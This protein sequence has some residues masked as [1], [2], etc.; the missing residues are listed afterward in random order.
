[1]R[2]DG[3]PFGSQEGAEIEATR[4]MR[5]PRRWLPPTHDTHLVIRR[6]ADAERGRVA[7]ARR[8]GGVER[9]RDAHVARGAGEPNDRQHHVRRALDATTTARAGVVD[10]DYFF[11]VVKRGSPS[12]RHATRLDRASTHDVTLDA[13]EKPSAPRK[14]DS[15]CVASESAVFTTAT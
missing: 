1:M 4:R 10:R 5:R 13:S 2:R 11:V 8:R 12:L 3:T 7:A 14:T 9:E 6:E 15:V